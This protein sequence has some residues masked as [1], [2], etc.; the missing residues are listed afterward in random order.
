MQN[1]YSTAIESDRVLAHE[2]IRTQAELYERTK[3]TELF[4]LPVFTLFVVTGGCQTTGLVLLSEKNTP[5]AINKSTVH[6]LLPFSLVKYY[7]M[8]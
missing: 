6:I 7:G 5:V 4:F 8:L 1:A 3:S 2:G